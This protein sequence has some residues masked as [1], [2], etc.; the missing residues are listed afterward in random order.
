[1]KTTRI[2]LIWFVVISCI[3]VYK[4]PDM[5]EKLPALMAALK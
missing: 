5:L 2:Y 4:L 3:A 1:M